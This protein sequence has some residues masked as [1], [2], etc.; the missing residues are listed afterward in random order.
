MSLPDYKAL[1]KLADTCRKL[2]IK[3]FKSADFE[4]TLSDEAPESNYK[5]RI[6]QQELSQQQ[7]VIE[8]AFK[9]DSLTDEQLLFWSAAN[10][11]STSESVES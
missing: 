2:G 10:L 1:K 8:E 5:K 3:H 6:K 9:S 7:S 11:E 4:F